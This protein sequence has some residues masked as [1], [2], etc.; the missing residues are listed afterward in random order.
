MIKAL[1]SKSIFQNQEGSTLHIHKY[2]SYII[3][4]R[5]IYYKYK[6]LASLYL[7]F[8]VHLLLVL[9]K[10]QYILMEQIIMHYLAAWLISYLPAFV[11][12]QEQTRKNSR[13]IKPLK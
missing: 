6:V 8:T 11:N 7:V 10:K 1:K 13:T 3:F 5:D 12:N 9:H 4:L 2:I